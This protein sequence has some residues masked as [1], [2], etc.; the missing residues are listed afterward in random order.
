MI[1]EIK[2][3]DVVIGDSTRY[4]RKAAMSMDREELEEFV[5][6]IPLAMFYEEKREYRILE[7]A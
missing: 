7:N 3:L 2:A 4:W 5:E 1:L 6:F